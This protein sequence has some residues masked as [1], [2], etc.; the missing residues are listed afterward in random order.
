V[1]VGSEYSVVIR[2]KL[3]IF[4]Y[5]GSGQ[6]KLFPQQKMNQKDRVGVNIEYIC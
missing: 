3:R 1:C 6:L 5:T 2:I 4:T